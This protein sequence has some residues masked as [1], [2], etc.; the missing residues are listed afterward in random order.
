MSGA[1]AADAEFAAMSDNKKNADVGRR[2]THASVFA[3]S[4]YIAGAGL[5]SIGQLL[6]ARM[7]G[8]TSYGIYAYVLAWAGSANRRGGSSARDAR[9]CQAEVIGAPS[10]LSTLLHAGVGRLPS[11]TMR[12]ML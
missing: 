9:F 3:L 10:A 6:I 12:R 7:V 4:I 2:L 11:Q 1:G 8:S 5:T